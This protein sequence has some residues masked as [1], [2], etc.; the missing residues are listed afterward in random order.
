MRLIDVD[1]I[2]ESATAISESGKLY[3]AWSAIVSA[4]TIEAKDLIRYTVDE[5]R[6]RI[7]YEI[8]ETEPTKHGKWFLI[9]E[10]SNA[11]VYCSVCH[12]KVY[13]EQYA[14]Q[15]IKSSYCPNCGAKMDLEEGE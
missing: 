13:R 6:R 8:I 5:E 7:R 10:C 3:V 11:G 2:P 14:N 1:A 4:P 15:K 12:K 9:D